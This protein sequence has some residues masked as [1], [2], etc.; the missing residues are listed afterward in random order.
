MYLEMDKD[1][2]ELNF[3][4]EGEQVALMLSIP[5]IRAKDE[6]EIEAS[7]N[8]C[9]SENEQE[10]IESGE[11]DNS[12]GNIESSDSAEDCDNSCHVSTPEEMNNNHS[13]EQEEYREECHS[14]N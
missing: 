7:L 12:E 8:S 1:M 13:N 4:Q 2:L 10:N 9:N 11:D 3:E 5:V 14:E 6:E